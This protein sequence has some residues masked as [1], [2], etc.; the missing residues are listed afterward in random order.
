MTPAEVTRDE[1]LVKLAMDAQLSEM[2]R[3][4]GAAPDEMLMSDLRA[5]GMRAA[6]AVIRAHD[7]A[8]PREGWQPIETAPKDGTEVLIW[9]KGWVLAPLAKWEFVGDEEGFLWTFDDA[10]C[11]GVDSGCLGW[12]E[13]I[14]GDAMPTH[15]RPLAA[16]EAETADGEG[17]RDG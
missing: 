3:F 10:I 14:E 17:G 6:L 16:H 5:A 2:S 1:A 12:A 11:L 7:A 13:D 8:A 15:W 9:R 4:L